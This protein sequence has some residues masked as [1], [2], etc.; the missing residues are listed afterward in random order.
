MAPGPITSWKIEGETWKQ[1]QISSSWALKS[2][3][4]VTAAMESEDSGF[5]AGKLRQN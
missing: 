1:W 5:L 2:Q 4:I 3:C